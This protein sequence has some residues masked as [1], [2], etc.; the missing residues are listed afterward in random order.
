MSRG[1][2]MTSDAKPMLDGRLRVLLLD[3]Y[4]PSHVD[5]VSTTGI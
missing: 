2:D 1:V 4:C 5:S 3:A